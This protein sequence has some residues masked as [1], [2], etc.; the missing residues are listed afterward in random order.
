MGALA[1][2]LNGVSGKLHV[3]TVSSTKA[4]KAPGSPYDLSYCGFSQN[5]PECPQ[6]IVVR[7]VP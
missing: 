4:V 2:A 6:T 7:S 5:A 3:Y 1:V